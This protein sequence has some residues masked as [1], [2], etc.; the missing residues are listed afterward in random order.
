MVGVENE[1]R[2]VNN[3][4]PKHLTSSE[5]QLPHLKIGVRVSVLCVCWGLNEKNACKAPEGWV[6]LYL[7]GKELG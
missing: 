4:Y 7:K 3:K 2:I 5:A 6:W 1:G